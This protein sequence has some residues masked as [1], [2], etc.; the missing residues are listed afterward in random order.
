MKNKNAGRLEFRGGIYGLIIPFL[1]LFVGIMW[2]ALTGKALPMAF[3]VPTLLAILSAFILAKNPRECADTII[4]GMASEV[5]AIMLMAWFLA[6]IIA[7]LMKITGLIQGLVWLGLS[8]GLKG[9]FFPVIS[10]LIGCLLSTATGT[11]IGTVIALG[12]ILYPVGVALGAGPQAMI[13][14]IVCAAYFGD[15]IAPVSDTTIASA[16]TQGTDVPGVVRTRLKYAFIAAGIGAILFLIFGGGGEITGDSMS[17]LGEVSPDGLIMLIVPAVLIFMMFKGVHLIIAL[18]SSCTLGIILAIS[19]GLLKVSDLLIIDM[20]SFSVGGLI[21][22]GIMGLIDISV[23]ALLL[24]GLVELLEAGGFLEIATGI[25]A[26]FTETPRGAELTVY[27][28][29]LIMNFLTVAN[30]IVI[31]MLGPFAK[32]ILVKKHRITPER[33]ANILDGVSCGIMCLIPYGFAPLLAYMFAGSSGAGVNFT[34]IS[35]IP[36]M[37]YGWAMLVVMLYS[38]LTGWARDYLSNEA[39][40]KILDGSGQSIYKM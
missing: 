3:W 8:I 15:N 32:E 30:T 35:V 16:Y 34:L 22:D 18:L 11:A 25:T 26:R 31:M 4:K 1:I 13:A 39:Y 9:S 38:I 27:I 33:S 6:G 17:F 40:E 12:P 5:V 2:L 10:F 21:V 19:T 28:L 36:Y 23:F 14:S 7:Q 37:F 20:N 29:I 24:M